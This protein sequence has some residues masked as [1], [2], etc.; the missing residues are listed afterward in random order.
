MRVVLKAEVTEVELK[1]EF[2][3]KPSGLTD[4][5]APKLRSFQSTLRVLNNTVGVKGSLIVSEKLDFGVLYEISLDTDQGQ[6]VAENQQVI[7]GE[8]LAG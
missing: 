2:V 8:I 3:K 6:Q 7:E 5:D 4:Y 1:E